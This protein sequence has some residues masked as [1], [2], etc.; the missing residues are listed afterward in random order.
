VFGVIYHTCITAAISDIIAIETLGKK[1]KFK[2]EQAVKAQW[3]EVLDVWISSFNLSGV[4]WSA[5]RPGC[6][7]PEKNS[8]T[9]VQ[10]AA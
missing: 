5:P 7:T 6:F 3:G 2:L 8:D 10:E 9:I 4:G 1:V